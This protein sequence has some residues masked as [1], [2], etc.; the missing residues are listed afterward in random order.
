MSD[1]TLKQE[2]GRTCEGGSELLTN[3]RGLSGWLGS[4]GNFANLILNMLMVR[5]E[6][7]ANL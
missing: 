7:H 4:G 6:P 1:V 5:I 2:T 3:W